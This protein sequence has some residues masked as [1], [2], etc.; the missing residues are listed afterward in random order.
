[1]S[2]VVLRPG[3]DQSYRIVEHDASLSV[4]VP[5]NVSQGAGLYAMSIQYV[6]F[7]TSVSGTCRTQEYRFLYRS[8]GSLT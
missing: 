1:M 4:G 5:A 6:A 3:T 8:Q 7:D 2:D